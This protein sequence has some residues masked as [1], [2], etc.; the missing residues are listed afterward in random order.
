[1]PATS[2]CST[3]CWRVLARCI[4]HGIRIVSNFGAANPRG[5]ALRIRALAR[6][7]GLPAPP[8]AVVS[9][10]DVSGP[11]HRAA[12]HERLG[13]A[14][15]DRTVVSANAYLGAEPI[16]QA[17]AARSADRG[18]RSR[19]RSIAGGRP[20]HGP[21]RLGCGRLEPP[22]SRD[23]GRPPARMRRPG[24]RRLLRRSRPQGRRR[25]ASPRLPHRA[26]RARRPLHDR[27]AAGHGRPG[28]RT[29]GEGAI[30]L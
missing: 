16:A 20:G 25:P 29:H 6:E 17:L 15:D 10:D 5:A 28:Q 30:A 22:C 9:G 1:M 2:R 12:L 14:L 7:L 8:I 21:L 19:V 23:H 26:D 11:S 13:Q 18:L 27:Q 4:R 24:H 3:P